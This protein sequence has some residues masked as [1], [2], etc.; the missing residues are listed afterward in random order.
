MSFQSP[1]HFDS[2]SLL[3]VKPEIENIIKNVE[4]AVTSLVEDGSMPFGIDDALINLEQ[5]SY[6]FRLIGQDYLGKLAE[7]TAKVMHKVISDSQEHKLKETDVAAMSEATI[8][9]KRYINFL[10]V[11]ETTAPQFLIPAMNH[12][13]SALNLPMT[14]EGQFLAPHLEAML[15]SVDRPVLSNVND[16]QYINRL[17]KLSLLHILNRKETD[18]DF[19]AMALCSEYLA[20][21]ADGL[22]SDQYWNFV[23]LAFKNL[24]NMILTEPR[25]RILSNIERQIALF[26]KQPQAFSVTSH[27][28]ADAISLCLSQED[29]ISQQLRS[30]L[31]ISDEILNDTQIENLSRQLYGPDLNTIQTITSLLSEYILD[32]Q[33]KLEISQNGQNT[34]Y[35]EITER[36]EECAKV[37]DVINLND[38]AQE[39]FVQVEKLK[40]NQFNTADANSANEML[41]SLLFATNSLQILERN[42]T[43][44][45][46]K[47]KF[48]NTK[49]TLAK[50]EEAQNILCNEARVSLQQV[51]EH[52][53]KYSQTQDI[54]ELRPVAAHLYSITGALKFMEADKLANLIQNTAETLDKQVIDE[55]VT[56]SMEQLRLL[57]NAIVSADF[58]F[59]QVQSQQPQIE[60]SLR[61]GQHSL[62]QF[63]QSLA[64]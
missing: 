35:H 22:N 31:P 48:H 39:L 7:L 59:E 42:Y 56:L 8:I 49:I 36:L 32:V 15:P 14:R 21:K 46:L 58:Y 20:K 37:L 10:A 6:V 57:A 52:I 54:D 47:S 25:L 63:E 62:S 2:T 64:S 5:S 50:V 34:D 17:Y 12:L 26:L 19:Q 3:I 60:R 38:A 41:N 9:M 61:L 18:L 44:N 4:N 30:Q 33:Q 40:T 43:P 51:N 55:K 29:Q 23:Y 24:D 16:S 11:G 45:R 1:T 13:E 27:D 28:Y 53:V